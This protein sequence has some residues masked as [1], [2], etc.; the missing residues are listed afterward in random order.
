MF[1]AGRGSWR[2]GRH[3]RD[4]SD[5]IAQIRCCRLPRAGVR[6]SRLGISHGWKYAAEL[7]LSIIHV[8]P[9]NC[10]YKSSTSETALFASNPGN[11]NERDQQKSGK[12]DKQH[13]DP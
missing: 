11:P 8:S 5:G 4:S 2:A 9:R 1:G 6:D 7:L 3:R 10:L 12:K 13:H